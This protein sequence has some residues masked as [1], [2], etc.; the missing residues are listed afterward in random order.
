MADTKTR[1]AGERQPSQL[2][3]INPLIDQ[4]GDPV[5]VQ[6]VLGLLSFLI[7]DATEKSITL[8][9]DDAHG[10]ALILETCKA[11]LANLPRNEVR[12]G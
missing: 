10:L 6:T 9:D 12:H 4:H 3:R 5:H 2:S 8:S 11:A 1:G 7:L